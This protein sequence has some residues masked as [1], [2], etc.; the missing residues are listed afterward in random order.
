MLT[1]APIE[2]LEERIARLEDKIS[3]VEERLVNASQN[4]VPRKRGWS[5]IIGVFADSP[6]FDQAIQ[7]GREW[8]NADRPLDDTTKS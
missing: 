2:I 4:A 1:K 7:I 5:S 8:R 3:E 6:D